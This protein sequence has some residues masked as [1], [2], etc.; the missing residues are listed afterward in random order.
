MQKEGAGALWVQQQQVR[1]GSENHNPELKGRAWGPR[2]GE[3]RL[4]LLPGQA[5][6]GCGG[7]AASPGSADCS[8]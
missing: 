7:Q 1:C 6:Q 4:G 3:G 5:P 2:L 8:P